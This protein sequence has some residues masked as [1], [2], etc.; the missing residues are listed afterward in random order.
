MKAN[1][2]LK[3]V[4]QIISVENTPKPQQTHHPSQPAGP[5][6]HQSHWSPG[7]SKAERL[8]RLQDGP[9]PP[10]YLGLPSLSL[11]KQKGTAADGP[12]GLSSQHTHIS[13]LWLLCQGWAEERK[14]KAPG[15]R[16][17]NHCSSYLRRNHSPGLKE[18]LC[19]GGNWRG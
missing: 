3:I 14:P 10:A 4:S 13:S 5:G 6:L 16:T 17:L 15:L 18:P 8:G 7:S 1:K 11:D 9:S 12:A 2:S 19:S